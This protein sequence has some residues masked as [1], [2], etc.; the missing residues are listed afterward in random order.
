MS[1]DPTPFV[2]L[3]H[4]KKSRLDKRL[5]ETGSDTAELSTVIE[6]AAAA[7]NG[8]VD[9]VQANSEIRTSWS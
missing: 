3:L 2:R 9:K 5:A 7:T 6:Y 1:T 8:V 4:A